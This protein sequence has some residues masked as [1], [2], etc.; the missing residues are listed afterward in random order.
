MAGPA[1]NSGPKMPFT[2]VQSGTCLNTVPHTVSLDF[3]ILLATLALQ[4]ADLPSCT[5]ISTYSQS[6]A[7][8]PG[9][10]VLIHKMGSVVVP[11][12]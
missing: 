9:L 1:W 4:S 11:A 12:S 8:P 10:D 7:F 2:S 5:S 3:L 6:Q